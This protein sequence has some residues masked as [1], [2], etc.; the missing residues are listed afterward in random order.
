[1][2]D[3][4][5]AM[6]WCILAERPGREIVVGAVTRPWE[7]NVVF[8]GVRPDEFRAFNEPGYVKIVWTLR[9]D[10]VSELESIFRTETRVST[11]DAMARRRFR[12]YWAR[13]SPGVV[14]IRRMSLGIL[15]ADAEGRT[16]VAL[17]RKA[18]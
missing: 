7:A 17:G 11:T 5:L 16:K 12:W 6:G 18:S 14:L 1:L 4:T 10:P 9:A 13:V 3:Q 8:R 2:L 15:K